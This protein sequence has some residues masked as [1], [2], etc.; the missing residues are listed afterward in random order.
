MRGT[1]LNL[2]RSRG[3]A[4]AETA[5]RK[6]H[7]YD[8]EDAPHRC[9]RDVAFRCTQEGGAVKSKILMGTVAAGVSVML[10]GAAAHAQVDDDD[11][12][13]PPTT[14]ISQAAPIPPPITLPRTGSDSVSDTVLIGATIAAAGGGLLLV[15]RRRRG[16]TAPA[17]Q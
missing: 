8:H 11:Y 13:L 1:V 2:R 17:A 4:T 12:T 15:S 6:R 14:T 3:D 16:G 7:E 10:G 5:R 9:L